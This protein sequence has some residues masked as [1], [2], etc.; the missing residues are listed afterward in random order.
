MKSPRE[1]KAPSLMEHCRSLTSHR[2]KAKRQF[3]SK[4]TL[5]STYFLA[6]SHS[7]SKKRFSD[8]L[9]SSFF[10]DSRNPM[11]RSGRSL[12]PLVSAACCP[13]RCPR[14]LTI[15]CLRARDPQFLTAVRVFPSSSCSWLSLHVGSTWG[16]SQGSC[17]QN[18]QT[19][20][21][22]FFVFWMVMLFLF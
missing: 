15:P 20:N 13:L 18:L 10:G 7:I 14:S 4:C 21:E 1:R 12:L 16:Q 11:Y 22:A 3:Y 5:K 6:L 2:V 8:F 9:N 17:P 19:L